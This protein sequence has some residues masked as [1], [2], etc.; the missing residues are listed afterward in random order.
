M[1]MSLPPDIQLQILRCIRGLENVEM[2]RPA[3]GVEY[4]YVDPRELK[5]E[6]DN[7]IHCIRTNM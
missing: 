7:R 5:R 6:P 4:D 1:S 2:V 3:Y